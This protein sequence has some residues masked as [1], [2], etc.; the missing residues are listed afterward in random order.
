MAKLSDWLKA[1]NITQKRFAEI[2]GANQA[3]VSRYCQDRV[4][5]RDRMAKIHSATNGEVTANDFFDLDDPDRAAPEVA[6]E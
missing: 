2:I 6:A 4:P 5:D 3:A 1:N